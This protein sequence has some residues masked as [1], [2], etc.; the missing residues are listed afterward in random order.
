MFLETGEMSNIAMTLPPPGL[1]PGL[2]SPD[3]RSRSQ[4][5]GVRPGLRVSAPANICGI[6][7][8][9]GARAGVKRQGVGDSFCANNP[10]TK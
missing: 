2:C 9:T 4:T 10:V 1:S 8:Q 5:I 6:P 7:P 3:P